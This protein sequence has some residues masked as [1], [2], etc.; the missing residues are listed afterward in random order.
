MKE[1]KHINDEERVKISAWLE[2]GLSQTEMAS[3]LGKHRSSISREFTRNAFRYDGSVST[4]QAKNQ[5]KKR[6]KEKS[7][8]QRKL[9]KDSPLR[10]VVVRLLKK[11]Y[12]PEQICGR[13]K[14]IRVNSDF[15]FSLCPET[16]YQFI[17]QQ[18]PELRT[19]LRQ[20]KGKYRRRYRSLQRIAE[21]K[22]QLNSRRIDKRPAIV[23][24]RARIGDWEGDTVVGK[25]RSG[26]I[27]TMVDR[28]TGYLVAKATKTKEAYKVRKAIEESFE[29]I[30]RKYKQTSTFDNGTEF[31]EYEQLEQATG[32]DVYFAYPYHSWERGTNENTNG[33]L[34]QFFPK[35]RDFSNITQQELDHA[36][37]LLN[38]RP[39]KRLLFRSPAELFHTCCT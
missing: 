3:R 35:T 29:D 14:K 10:A 19:H 37:S 25:N 11:Y 36:V 24:A 17:Y 23:E 39:R 13:L 8:C 5:I 21:R 30:P 12:S 26:Y 38:N 18:R 16:I 27:V 28:K 1:Y 15:S 33:L 9:V 31:L 34:R 4:W 20:Q 22:K 32:L 6:R 2:L 7:L